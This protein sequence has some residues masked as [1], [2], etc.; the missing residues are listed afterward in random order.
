M[1]SVVASAA[2]AVGKVRTVHIIYKNHEPFEDQ[3]V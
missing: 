3:F 2:A 1:G